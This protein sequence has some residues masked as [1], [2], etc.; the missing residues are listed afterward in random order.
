METPLRI[1][2]ARADDLL[3]PAAP[4]KRQLATRNRILVVAEALFGEYGY[5]NFT[6]RLLADALT[7]EPRTLH[8]YFA[9][10]EVLLAAI[11]LAHLQ[12]L[13]NIFAQI[14][15][16]TENRGRQ[17]R[18]AYVAATHTTFGEITN[19]H[20]LL[21]KHLHTLPEDL[22]PVIQ[23]MHAVL[24]LNLAST[25]GE[26]IMQQLDSPRPDLK[27]IESHLQNHTYDR[28]A[29]SSTPAQASPA[30][31]HTAPPPIESVPPL[32]RARTNVATIKTVSVQHPLFR[33]A[34]HRVPAW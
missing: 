12:K 4:S 16:G 28:R 18:E 6:P 25:L 2:R 26:E 11:L 21:L 24:T 15:P 27:S 22:A 10:L 29:C 19:T 30:A 13:T 8:R 34:C 17:W 33:P 14:P 32:A 9:D 1:L 31:T 5:E 23:Q 7:M 20:A 3:P